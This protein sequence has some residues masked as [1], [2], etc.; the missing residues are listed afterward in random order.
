MNALV[1]PDHRIRLLAQPAKAAIAPE[2]EAVF[3]GQAAATPAFVSAAAALAAAAALGFVPADDDTT[4]NNL[5]LAF[6]DIGSF[7]TAFPGDDSWL[8]RAV[9]DYFAAGGLRAWVVRVAMDAAA[10][11]DAYVSTSPS[12]L[13]TEP[14]NGIAIAAQIPD[15]GLLVLPDLEYFC[16]AATLP[17]PAPPPAPPVAA[18]FRP[19]SDFIAT[20]SAPAAQ[21]TPA[22]T[23]RPL[24]VLAR[25]SAAL[26]VLRPDMLCLFALPVGADPT[27]SQP[28]LAKRAIAYVHGPAG[29]NAAATDMPQIQALAPLVQ[30]VSG[31]IATPSG[32]VAGLLCAVAQSDGVWRSIAGR[33]L[34]LGVTPLRR[35]ESS[36]LAL[37]RSS[38][39]AVLR[40][41]QGG[42]ILDD[43]ILACQQHLP[44]AALRR[45][46]PGR[47]LIGW[48]VRNLQQFGEQLIFENELDDG[49]VELV[50]TS[51]FAELFKRGALAGGQVSDA[52]RITRRDLGKRNTYAFDIAVATVV[53]VETIRLQFLDGALT[54]TL[55]A[56]A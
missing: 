19:I 31:D 52:V 27:Q 17:P 18:V 42:T 14:Q 32:V 41:T 11:L 28:V 49:R 15:A 48:L 7:V 36:A 9:R 43:D 45:A 3:V 26:A 25:V 46:A 23:I 37:L 12:I 33:A 53:A 24:D 8:A 55:G 35:I 6:T 56:A 29:P 13:A 34:P 22:T 38:G 20:P 39:I 47:R 10:P 54:T 21:P 50:L 30:D 16:L 44:G 4:L 1:S 5:P 40:F 2:L 51:L